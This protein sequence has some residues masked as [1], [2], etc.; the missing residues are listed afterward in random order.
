MR[1]DGTRLQEFREGMLEDGLTANAIGADRKGRVETRFP[2]RTSYL[3]NSKHFDR[4]PARAPN[5]EMRM[6]CAPAG[7]G[8]S[9]PRAAW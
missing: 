4:N 6:D 8:S 3:A 5:K 9:E 2:L 7:L 1:S